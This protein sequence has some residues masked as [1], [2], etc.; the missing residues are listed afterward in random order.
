MRYSRKI[1]PSLPLGTFAG[2]GSLATFPPPDIAN[3]LLFAVR[4]AIVFSRRFPAR[5]DQRYAIRTKP[6]AE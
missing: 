2:L 1:I 6:A 3:P 5:V 4:S